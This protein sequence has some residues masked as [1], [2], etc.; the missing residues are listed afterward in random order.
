[1]WAKVEDGR[2]VNMI[3][4]TGWFTSGE[5]QYQQDIFRQ[6]SKEDLEEKGF[7]PVQFAGK[8]PKNEVEMSRDYIFNGEQVVEMINTQPKSTETLLHEAD[9]SE[10]HKD[11]QIV[12]VQAGEVLEL[13]DD[14]LNMLSTLGII[15]DQDIPD[16]LKTRLKQYK[17][18]GSRINEYNK[19]RN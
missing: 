17:E 12:N 15:N 19:T 4:K 5:F 2:F 3:P 8:I 6:W 7:Y 9:N 10:H 16:R 13:V 11:V 1:M 14:M 18:A